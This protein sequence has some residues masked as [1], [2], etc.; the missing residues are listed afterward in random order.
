MRLMYE[1]GAY[2]TLSSFEEKDIAKQAGFRWDPGA[3]R[4]YTKDPEKA[5][6]LAQYAVDAQVRTSLEQVH[7][8]REATKAM[9]RAATA[10]LDVPVPEGLH[11]LPFQKAGVQ[12][13]LNKNR[14]LLADQMGLGKTIQAIGLL[15]SL[16]K[17]HRVLVVC[18]ASLRLN[19]QRE[20]QRWD[21][22]AYTI[23]IANGSHWPCQGQEVTIINYD[24]L[25]KHTGPLAAQWQCLIVDE[26]HYG[27][28]PK[29]QRSIAL[30]TIKAD[31]AIFLTGTPILNRPVEIW[32]ALHYLDP[33]A[34][35]NFFYFGK[36]YCD[37]H[38]EAVARRKIVWNFSGA[39]HLE[40]LQDKL[41]STIM[42]RRLKQDVLTELPPKTRQ[43]IEVPPNGLSGLVAHEQAMLARH[44]DVMVTLK[45]EVE[46]AKASEDPDAY[47]QAVERLRNGMAVAFTE[48]ATVRHAT[49]VAKIPFVVEHLQNV[50]ESE[51]KVVVW[52]H[53]HDVVA[54]IAAAF[55]EGS[56]VVF[57]GETPMKARQEAVDRFQND[58]SCRLFIGS[59]AAAGVGITLT[60]A[61]HEVFA[62]LDWVPAN[63]TQAED[64]CHRIGT[65]NPVLIQHLVLDGSLDATMAKT[66]VRK[67]EIID[68]ALD[69]EREELHIP[70]LPLSPQEEG[71]IFPSAKTVAQEAPGL[72]P[73]TIA[74]V[75][76]G[77]QML[78][79]VCDGARRLDGAGFSKIDTHIGRSLAG[80]LRLTP[81]QAVLGLRLIRK[82]KRQLPEEITM[83]LTTKE[84][85]G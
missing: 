34:W 59:I 61:S 23:G 43:V 55:P 31:R 33:G 1:N 76:Q 65:V 35:Q 67:Q 62:E 54:G 22:H 3:K 73:A 39:S 7:Q 74:L 51:A 30:Y 66:L 36:R 78:A 48:V 53:H 60:A 75:H 37:A 19:W 49:A 77:L 57:T 64:R 38:Q 68:R 79:G 58:P 69:T 12:F 28:N 18:P 80:A 40:E 10:D 50:L 4:W 17:M 42:L 15:N 47:D 8:D 41:R 46:L 52:C 84:H 16:P 26:S 11:L 21:V 72:S 70:L 9:S 63:I 13:L 32:P 85:N 27:K 5:R 2:Y 14:V 6:K 82:Y 44:M 29:A 45:A 20:M 56:Y 25:T 83:V 71:T 24:I 81:K